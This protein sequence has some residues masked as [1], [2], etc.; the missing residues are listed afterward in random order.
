MSEH[1]TPI[2]KYII[3]LPD[4]IKY[5][6]STKLTNPNEEISLFIL[7]SLAEIGINKEEIIQLIKFCLLPSSILLYKKIIYSLD[8]N[9]IDKLIHSHISHLTTFNE[10]DINDDL[11]RLHI[12]TLLLSKNSAIKHI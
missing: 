8:Y 5:L 7:Q 11:F 2:Y 6:L 12:K 10:F 1:H 3:N 4:E 9:Q